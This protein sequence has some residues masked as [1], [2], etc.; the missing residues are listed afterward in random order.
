MFDLDLI[1]GLVLTAIGGM[2]IITFILFYSDK[3]R[4]LKRKYRISEKQLLTCS[5]AL[6]GVGAWL[7]MVVFRHK[8]R[9]LV[10]RISLPAAALITVLAIVFLLIQ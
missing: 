5:F 9:H 7:G 2:N 6:G 1:Q 4:A 3:Q 8:T 10:F